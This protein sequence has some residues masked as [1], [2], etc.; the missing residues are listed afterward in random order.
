M[1]KVN[2]KIEYALMALKFIATREDGKLTSAR[3]I[4]DKFHTPFDTTAK[5]MQTMNS[6]EI[7]TSV[8]GIKGGYSLNKDLETVT[9]MDLVRMI[10]GKESQSICQ[11]KSGL[12][13][14]LGTCNISAPMQKLYEKVN[15]YLEE[16]TLKELLL[17]EPQILEQ[18]INQS[19][20]NV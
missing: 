1:L 14:F 15:G 10:E 19:E 11:S 12:C 13:E 7:L 9:F 4:C 16:L 5:V 17:D 2:K 18:M 6:N 3:E 20:I 8:K